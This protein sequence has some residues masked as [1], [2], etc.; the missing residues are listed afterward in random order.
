LFRAYQFDPQ[1]I[2]AERMLDWSPY[3]NPVEH[4]DRLE[5][6]A[7]AGLLER[8]GDGQYALTGKGRS[9]MDEISDGFY[10]LLGE[11]PVLTP[12]RSEMLE[13]LLKKLVD[14]SLDA[15]QPASK[16]RLAVVHGAHPDGQYSRMA[17]IDMHI[18][19][20]NAF[21]DDSHIAAWHGLDVS[22]Q[23]WEAFT[24]VWRDKAA[25]GA[26]LAEKLPFRG[27]S[28]ESYEEAL[29]SLVDKGW[30]H[31]TGSGY[32]MTEAGAAV[33]Q[34]AEDDTNRAFF[35]PWEAIRQVDVNRLRFLL[36][37]LKKELEEL[38]SS[39]EITP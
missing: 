1:P 4:A 37:R 14:A 30:L 8:T 23:A 17:R 2:S 5:R 9:A 25:D 33:R 6:V 13:G 31:K 34:Q 39:K 29:Q 12:E 35:A 36:A 26:A 19:D 24:F 3:F 20:L 18:D 10:L 22:P 16:L 15:G 28:A 21:R 11:L 7:E 32:G 38:E 27:F